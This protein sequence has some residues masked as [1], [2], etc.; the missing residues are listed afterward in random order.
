MTGS[1]DISALLDIYLSWENDFKK[2]EKA[3]LKSKA[4][5]NSK[6]IPA[7][8]KLFDTLIAE[9][10]KFTATITD[11]RYLLCC[12]VFDTFFNPKRNISINPNEFTVEFRNKGANCIF[13]SIS[14]ETLENYDR[15]AKNGKFQD[16]PNFLND[17]FSIM[18]GDFRELIKTADLNKCKDFITLGGKKT[19]NANIGNFISQLCVINDYSLGQCEVIHDDTESFKKVFLETARFLNEALPQQD[20][21]NGLRFTKFSKVEKIY[22]EDSKGSPLLR[23]ADLLSGSISHLLKAKAGEYSEQQRLLFKSVFV[24]SGLLK[25]RLLFWTLPNKTFEALGEV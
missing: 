2:G 21:G 25:S 5:L 16:L 9:G 24:D 22:F 4:I 15:M 8:I 14:D 17:L 7:L 19:D 12:K 10:V 6:G 18:S 20:F 11:K 13:N 23:A 1:D 3:E